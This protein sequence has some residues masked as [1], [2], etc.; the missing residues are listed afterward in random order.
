MAEEFKIGSN[1]QKVKLEENGKNMQSAQGHEEVVDSYI[2]AEVK[3]GRLL[4][5]GT[6][7]QARELG[8][9]CTHS[10]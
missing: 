8:I 9:H 1:A 5:V 10:G 7:L 3:Q 6:P 4:Q 2:E